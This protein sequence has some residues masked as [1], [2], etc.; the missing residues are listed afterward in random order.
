VDISRIQFQNAKTD[1]VQAAIRAFLCLPMEM[2]EIRNGQ[3][4]SPPPKRVTPAVLAPH[5]GNDLGRANALMS[6]LISSG[7]LDASGKPLAL[8]MALAHDKSLSRIPRE[9]VDGIIA[10]LV[11]EAKRLNARVHARVF[12]ER[13]DLFGSTLREGT[14]FGDVDVIVHLT[15]PTEDFT[16]EDMEEQDVVIAALQDVSEHINMTCPFDEVAVRAATKTIY[17]RQA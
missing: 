6:E 9:T 3:L 5:L 8:A 4:V 14:D 16:P 13:L 7:Y 2:P 10:R 17:T 1:E 15:D 12:V 11:V